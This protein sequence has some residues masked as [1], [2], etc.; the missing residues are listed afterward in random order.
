[1]VVYLAIKNQRKIL[2]KY[3]SQKASDVWPKYF[4]C[5]GG[6]GGDGGGKYDDIKVA[7]TKPR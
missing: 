4:C 2:V 5:L 3:P 7:F 6:R 1:M